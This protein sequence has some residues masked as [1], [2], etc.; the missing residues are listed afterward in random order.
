MRNNPLFAESKPKPTGATNDRFIR[1]WLAS[2]EI[3]VHPDGS[4]T[5]TKTGKPV[6]IVDNGMGYL[7]VPIPSRFTGSVSKI[8]RVHRIIAIHLF[9]ESVTPEMDVNHIDFDSK[10]NSFSNLEI[11]P[12]DQ[13]SKLGRKGR[14]VSKAAP[15]FSQEQVVNIRKRFIS[16]HKVSD[17]ARDLNRRLR[18]ITEIVGNKRYPDSNYVYVSNGQ[19]YRGRA[20]YKSV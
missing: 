17:I 4:I 16:G 12:K 7:V 6:N 8:A 15:R 14:T 19:G 18:T 10:N 5:K 3:M 11:L 13:H 1:K 20:Y 2:G 9:G